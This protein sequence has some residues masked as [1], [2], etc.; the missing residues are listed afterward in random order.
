M[1]QW[2]SDFP[3]CPAT[4]IKLKA[5]LLWKVAEALMQD[6]VQ[7]WEDKWL[8]DRR[9]SSANALGWGKQGLVA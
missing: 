7:Q 5:M 9:P 4:I 2:D 1:C 6:A 3:S 8:P